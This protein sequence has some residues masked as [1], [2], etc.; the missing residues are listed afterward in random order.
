MS[1]VLQLR[2]QLVLIG[3]YLF[4]CRNIKN[5]E[6]GERSVPKH[7]VYTDVHLYSLKVL[8]KV[9]CAKLMLNYSKICRKIM[10]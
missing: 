10:I 2:K 9:Q 5:A 1:K 8:F 4:T 3:A 6:D 7:Y